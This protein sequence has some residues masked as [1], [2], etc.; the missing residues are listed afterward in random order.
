PLA[1][2]RFPRSAFDVVSLVEVLEHV[3]EPGRLLDQACA[4]LR[5][6]GLLFGTTP[7]ALSLNRRVLG[8]GWSIFCAPEHV[9]VWTPGALRRSLEE[10]GLRVLRIQTHGLNPSEIQTRLRKARTG[11]TPAVPK[12]SCLRP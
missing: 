6:G 12:R 5:P 8:V 4:F 9:V 10:R 1:D 11:K 3:R 7:N 2:P